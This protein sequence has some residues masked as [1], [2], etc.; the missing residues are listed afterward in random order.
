VTAMVQEA[1]AASVAPQVVVSAKSVGLA[2][3]RVM[4]LI[5]SVALPV[6]DSVKV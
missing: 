2:P 6:F 1:D 3:V 5:F 4:L